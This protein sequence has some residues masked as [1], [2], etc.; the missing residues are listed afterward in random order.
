MTSP[1]QRRSRP[2][3]QQTERERDVL[4]L[5]QVIRARRH[6]N[7]QKAHF[8]AGDEAATTLRLVRGSQSRS[9]P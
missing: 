9:K 7:E 5:K 3:K 6:R 2:P 1:D 8:T 4:R